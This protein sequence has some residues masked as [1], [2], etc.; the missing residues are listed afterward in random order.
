MDIDELLESYDPI[1]L[2]FQ[3]RFHPPKKKESD[4]FIPSREEVEKILL[5]EPIRRLQKECS[6]DQRI[7]IL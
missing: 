2:K 3:E 4:S 7:K 6:D 5:R 1:D